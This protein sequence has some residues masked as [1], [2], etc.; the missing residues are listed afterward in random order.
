MS[1]IS[2]KLLLKKKNTLRRRTESILTPGDTLELSR[3]ILHYP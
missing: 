3:K 2:I 1:C